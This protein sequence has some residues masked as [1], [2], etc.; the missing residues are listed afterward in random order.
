MGGDLICTPS[1]P[2]FQPGAV[3]GWRHLC[4][5]L[6]CHLWPNTVRVGGRWTLRTAP[7]PDLG[8]T[9]PASSPPPS[10]P[11]SCL[12]PSEDRVSSPVLGR[13]PEKIAEAQLPFL[14]F[15]PTKAGAYDLAPQQWE[16]RQYPNFPFWD[17]GSPANPARILLRRRG[18]QKV[19]CSAND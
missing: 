3:P 1:L 7:F 19:C 17:P 2:T 9:A 8:V 10:L 18:T 15:T 11:A 13:I 5:S 16:G 12:S 14:G 6:A 4:L